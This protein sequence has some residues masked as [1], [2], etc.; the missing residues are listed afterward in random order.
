MM[1]NN[2]PM[3][4][5]ERADKR[6]TRKLKNMAL[7]T[8]GVMAPDVR[9]LFIERSGII[10]EPIVER[11]DFTHRT[12]QEFLAAQAAL[13]EG[14][15]GVLVSN[16]HDDQWREVIILAAGLASTKVREELIGGLIHRGDKETH[17]RHQLHLLAVAC[18]ETS[19]ELGPIVRQEVQKR[20]ASLVPPKNITEAKELASAGELAVPYLAEGVK[21]R[22]PVAAACV[23]ALSLIGGEAALMALESYGSDTRNTVWKELWKAADSFEREEYIRRVLSQFRA[24]RLN[25]DRVSSLDGFRLLSSLE[26]LTVRTVGQMSDLSPL[27]ALTNLSSLE[28]SGFGQVSDLSPLAGLTKLSSLELWSFGQVN[29]LSPLAGLSN[30]TRRV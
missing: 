7:D 23:R 24:K 14:D 10:R 25:L 29:D 21:E 1:T 18:L 16:A 27:A 20:L 15:I 19:V 2:W 30:L 11:I 4:P 17:R 26:S 5:V 13:D 12:F 6:L 22:A 3:V 8:K 28:L 9:R